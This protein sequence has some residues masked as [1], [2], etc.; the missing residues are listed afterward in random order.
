MVKKWRLKS[1]YALKAPYSH[2]L[3]CFE[4]THLAQPNNPPLIVCSAQWHHNIPPLPHP[5]P[6]ANLWNLYVGSSKCYQ[7]PSKE[8]QQI[9]C[10]RLLS[11]GWV[12]WGEGGR[13]GRGGEW[14]GGGGRGGGGRVGRG[15]GRG[16]DKKVNIPL[17]D[18]VKHCKRDMSSLRTQ[19][20]SK[21]QTWTQTTQPPEH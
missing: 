19:H 11:M 1:A 5:P 4:T 3:S 8:F 14:R 21:A 7:F 9:L 20:Y 6:L 15:G 13:G 18:K 10:Q 2:T 16:G 17:K 12:G